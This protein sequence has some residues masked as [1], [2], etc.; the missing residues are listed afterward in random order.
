MDILE[1]IIFFKR[2]DNVTN[3]PCIG[4]ELD[5]RKLYFNWLKCHDDGCSAKLCS[6]QFREW[7]SC[8][9]KNREIRVRNTKNKIKM[10]EMKE[11]QAWGTFNGNSRR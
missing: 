3:A 4:K 10:D 8:V 11:E 5:C 9:V 7:K 6:I 2:M 1:D